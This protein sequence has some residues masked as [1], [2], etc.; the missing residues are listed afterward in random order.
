[1][2]TFERLIY[3]GHFPLRRVASEDYLI[4]TEYP[5]GYRDDAVIGAPIELHSWELSF[6]H[7]SH[8]KYVQL[9][10]GERK[11]RFEYLRDFRRDSKSQG[12][13]PFVVRD[14]VDLKDYLAIFADDSVSM[15]VTKTE[16]QPMQMATT[17]PIKQVLVR[18]VDFLDDGSLGDYAEA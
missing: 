3:R 9:P 15:D 14:P 11:A 13:R 4:S 10:T 2:P 12:N 16:S 7:V 8:L 6:P 18:G 5:G 17:M 1:V